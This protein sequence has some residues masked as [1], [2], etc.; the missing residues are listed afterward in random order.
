MEIPTYENQ[1]N[2]KFILD[3]EDAVPVFHCTKQWL[4]DAK[5]YYT[6]D[7]HASDFV[8]IT[9]DYSALFQVLAFYEADEQR[10]VL[11]D[12]FD[13][14]SFCSKQI[15][16]KT[17]DLSLTFAQIFPRQCKM[18]KRRVDMLEHLVSSL[19]H[20][21]YLVL[22]RQLWYELGETYFEMLHLKLGKMR[23][24]NPDE[25]A[26][27]PQFLNKLNL[28]TQKSIDNFGHFLHSVYKEG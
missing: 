16:T 2:C 24:R 6:L 4:E 20:Q 26:P 17:N 3:Y 5:G 25:A 21:C 13:L 18:H 15:V 7:E 22:C 28:L 27:D 23:E 14:T 1:V 10:Y 9:Q 11:D 19:N 12:F 8:R